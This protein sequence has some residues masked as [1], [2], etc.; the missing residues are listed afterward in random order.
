MPIEGGSCSFIGDQGPKDGPRLPLSLCPLSGLILPRQLLPLV[1][2]SK[3]LQTYRTE[4]AK[5]SAYGHD[6]GWPLVLLIYF[7]IFFCCAAIF[8]DYSAFGREAGP[9]T[10]FG[11]KNRVFKEQAP[12]PPPS[13]LL[14]ETG[15]Q[16]TPWGREGCSCKEQFS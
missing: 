15:T 6:T 11:E 3:Q 5:N 16:E 4:R 2:W 14:H 10:T 12:P 13:R 8:L 7:S 9:R 1:F